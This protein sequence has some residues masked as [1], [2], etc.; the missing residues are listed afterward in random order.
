MFGFRL[1]IPTV[2]T[3]NTVILPETSEMIQTYNTPQPPNQSHRF[4]LRL[5][6]VP[7]QKSRWQLDSLGAIAGRNPVE[8]SGGLYSR[9]VGVLNKDSHNI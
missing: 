7:T 2:H 1:E 4:L 8:E 3:A 5:G 6:I 9:Q